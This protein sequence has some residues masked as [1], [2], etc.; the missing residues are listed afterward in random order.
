M[1]VDMEDRVHRFVTRLGPHLIKDCMMA[2]LQG[3]IDISGILAYAQ[4]LEDLERQQGT[5]QDPNRGCYKRARSAGYSGAYQEELYRL[6][7]LGVCLLDS[8]D[9]RITLQ[10][11]SQS[12][13]ASDVKTQQN[14][15][16][17]FASIKNG[18]QQN[19]ISAF[20]LDSNGILKYR[21]RLCDPNVTGLRDRIMSE[22]HYSQ[23]TKSA[24]FLPIRTTYAAEDY[25]KL[26]LKEISEGQAER[27]IQTLEDMLRACV[28]D[29]QG[30]WDDHFPLIEFSYDNSY[31]ASIKMAPY[32]ALYGR[33][34]RPRAGWFIVGEAN[35]F[36]PELV[37]QAIEK[38]YDDEN[39]S[40]RIIPVD[41]IQVI[42]NLTY[43][44]EPIVI[45]DR[46]VRRLRSKEVA[47]VKVLWRSKYRE[48]M[49]WV[50]EA[51]MKS[52]YP[53]LF[54]VTDDTI[55]EESL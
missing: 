6:A 7:N 16:P 15:D 29:F 52:K 18:V 4:N 22:F 14:K 1:V 5:E 37:H 49:T 11:I 23:L 12:T 35:V 55:P 43:E 34:C 45:L 50:A 10:N 27:T 8:E 32:E 17:A 47:S 44:E 24:S 41:D 9:T 33:K 25:A 51:K 20:E 31:H 36:G 21:G 28:L 2:S 39:W 30:S 3:G 46:Q 38:M 19:Q 40:F 54:P 13:L 48:E 42:E 26:Y 53:H